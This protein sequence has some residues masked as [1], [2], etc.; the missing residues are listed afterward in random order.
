MWPMRT[1]V[2]ELCKRLWLPK[3]GDEL[4][5]AILKLLPNFASQTRAALSSMVWKTGLNSPG[6]ELMTRRTSDV[7][8]CCSS[9]SLRSSVRWRSSLSNRVFSMAMTA[10]AAK[11]CTSS[12][13][14]SVKGRTS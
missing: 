4:H 8:I 1:S 14:L 3:H 13:C 9:D 7:A 11:L 2:K 6:D 10:W 5:D 12:I